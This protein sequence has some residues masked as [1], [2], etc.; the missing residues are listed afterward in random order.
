MNKH[1]IKNILYI[2]ILIVLTSCVSKYN[3]VSD[4]FYSRD[5]NY[6]LY[7]CNEPL[8][9]S[10][11]FNQNYAIEDSDLNKI[12]FNKREKSFFKKLDISLNEV[13]ILT[14]LKVNM[15]VPMRAVVFKTQK[16][17]LKD[18]EVVKKK[19][20]TFF[21][22]NAILDGILYYQVAFFYQESYYHIVQYGENIKPKEQ[23]IYE[24]VKENME[25]AIYYQISNTI[26]RLNEGITDCDLPDLFSLFNGNFNDG[27]N[28]LSTE[29]NAP[30]FHYYRSDKD[31]GLF[32]QL[33]AFHYSFS[34][35]LDKAI[36]VFPHK[37]PR[38]FAK[39]YFHNFTYDSLLN[40]GTKNK[41][42]IINEAHHM[43]HHRY[44]VGTLL[45]DYYN[46]GYR[47]LGLEALST[48]VKSIKNNLKHTDGYYVSDPVMANLIREADNMGYTVFGYDEPSKEREKNQVKLIMEKT[49]G[50]RASDK[51][52]ILAGWSH[53]N[54]D[55]YWMAYELKNLHQ[56][57]PF[58]INQTEA[59]LKF[60]KKRS[61]KILEMDYFNSSK[62]DLYLYNS[63][64][65]ENNCFSI[66]NSKTH[67][68][69]IPNK[70]LERKNKYVVLAYYKEDFESNE[71][72]IPTFVK[73]ISGTSK[74]I[75]LPLCLGTYLIIIKNSEGSLVFKEEI[76]V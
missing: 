60:E 13:S 55:N 58:T 42:V 4:G 32:K 53:V 61:N 50:K 5:A 75:N 3:L 25:N 26:N 73:V 7:Y 51:I 23:D 11:C 46:L 8:E 48:E 15:G 57:N 68:F 14:G 37:K 62:S 24:H 34:G 31:K 40:I 44:F 30:Y 20:V 56:I 65:I 36:A 2:T 39:K 28:Y 74:K 63:L 12:R 64:K 71:K 67:S 35:E 17:N 59:E 27:Q 10:I 1:K 69:V 19:G 6:N 22:K 47:Y 49:E 45:K 38:P 9:T 29:K 41:V 76:S 70:K 16:N 43:P 72:A 33:Q 66:R 18:F 21:A 54:E 52:L